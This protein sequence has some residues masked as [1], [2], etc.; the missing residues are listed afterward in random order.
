MAFTLF[1]LEPDGSERY[2]GEESSWSSA[3]LQV[4]IASLRSSAKYAIHNEKIGL[5]VIVDLHS[6]Q[7]TLDQHADKL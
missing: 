7:K 3:L 5:R 1:R 6:Q 4:E 2:I